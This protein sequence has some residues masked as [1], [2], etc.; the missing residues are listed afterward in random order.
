MVRRPS[1]R[2]CLLVVILTIL[3]LLMSACSS[4]GSPNS[5]T[6]AA[7]S[8]PPTKGSAVPLL[9]GFVPKS[10]VLEAL[11]RSDFTV[12]GN[13]TKAARHNAD[14]T[15][16]AG[17]RCAVSVPGGGTV[18][19]LEIQ[20]VPLKG[21]AGAGIIRAAALE[22][23]A[24]YPSNVGIG[25]ANNLGY[26]NPNGRESAVSGLLRGDWMLTLSIAMPGAGRDAI[27]DVMALA[28]EVVAELK[29]PLKPTTPYPNAYPSGLSPS[30]TPTS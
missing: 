28:E 26:Q 11:G 15:V 6:D 17:A 29:L 8:S 24:H 5:P 25:F 3:A 19:A 13:V 10:S 22:M 7:P 18:P 12:T 20:V 9:C 21:N 23:N 4:S 2:W 16:L 1:P 27:A 30:A 14:G